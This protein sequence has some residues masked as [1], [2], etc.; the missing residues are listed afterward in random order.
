M[1]GHEQLPRVIGVGPQQSD[2][3]TV[4]PDILAAGQSTGHLLYRSA[5][6]LRTILVGGVA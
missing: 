5:V 3:P 4:D 6:A 2:A 1:F